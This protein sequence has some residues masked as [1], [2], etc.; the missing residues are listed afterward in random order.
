M[1]I[2]VRVLGIQH[3]PI[4]QQCVE[5]AN[6]MEKENGKQNWVADIVRNFEYRFDRERAQLVIQ[7]QNN[8]NS[9]QEDEK[10]TDHNDVIVTLNGSNEV[11][12]NLSFNNRI[13]SGESFV[14]FVSRRSDFRLF[15]VPDADPQSYVSLARLHHRRFLKSTGCHFSWMLIKQGDVPLGRITF[16]LFSNKA[17]RTCQNF[18]Y[19]CRGDLPDVEAEITTNIDGQE[20]STK[21]QKIQLTYKNSRIFR[22]VGPNGW[23]QG[24]DIVDP[25]RGNGGFSV[26][27]RH[28]PD[29]TF[30]IEHND[31]GIVGM[32]ND[33]EHTNASSFYITLGPAAWMN[34]RYVAFGRVVEGLKVL[35]ALKLVQT[36]H[37]QSPV[38][39]ITIADCGEI[40]TEV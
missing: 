12:T 30:E 1:P 37:N 4:F 36:K 7:S 17:P 9:Q 8:N 2:I 21:K 19:L 20:P 10:I 23:I 28:F 34:K 6:H 5:A 22:V 18:L 13:F 24:G 33:G 14:N 27:G 11:D 25:K 15:S 40:N 26:Y 29:E 32:S 39:D 16:Q 35:R 3:N 38:Q 31:E